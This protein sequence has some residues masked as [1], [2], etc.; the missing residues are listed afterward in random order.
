MVSN[1]A[2][3]FACLPLR[4][5]LRARESIFFP[6]G[7]A[8]NILRGGFGLAFKSVAC[9]P[10]CT[11]AGQCPY[12][13]S[14]AYATIFEPRSNSGPSG[15]ADPPRPFV[16]RARH[17]D[18][19]RINSG[20]NFC[21]DAHLFHTSL[22]TIAYFISAFRTLADAGIGPRRG[23]AELESVSTLTDRRVPGAILF[24]RGALTIPVS[25]APIAIS[26]SA[27]PSPVRKIQVHFRSPTELSKNEGPSAA[28]EFGFLFARLRDRISNLQTLYGGGTL[29]ID[30]RATGER[31]RQI[32]LT[33]SSL[34][35]IATER[36]SSRTSHR[37]SIGGFS[38][39]A[40]YAGDLAEFV[41]Y[42]HAGFWTGVGRHA[43]W[44]NGEIDVVAE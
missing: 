26:L 40:E 24:S 43:V 21:F 3:S 13:S 2:L 10:A 7:K 12:A 17:L 11:T 5:D 28:P 18:G 32:K 27:S 35:R 22:Q 9:D 23:A 37:H 41:P 44:G 25:L 38:G 1:V 42:L 30:F 34:Q 39:T 4:F 33:E 8:A 14:C 36:L 29:P 6:P 20:E 19:R 16:F 15:L 31:A